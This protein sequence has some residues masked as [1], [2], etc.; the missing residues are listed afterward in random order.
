[1]NKRWLSRQYAPVL[2]DTELAIMQLLWR[3][4]KVDAKQALASLNC[5][6]ITLSTVQST[7]ERLCRKSMVERSK[8]GRAYVYRAAVSRQTLISRLIGDI[9]RQVSADQFEPVLSGFVDLLTQS[10]PASLDRLQQM[11]ERKRLERD[12]G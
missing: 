6:S 12:D 10:D 11:I 2:G 9:A 7:L 8:Q 1:M 3:N 4:G 5:R